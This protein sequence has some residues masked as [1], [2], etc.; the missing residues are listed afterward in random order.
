MSR[1]IERTPRDS[2]ETAV[3]RRI[4]GISTAQ[5]PF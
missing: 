3:F 2:L 4:A 5:E 1:L